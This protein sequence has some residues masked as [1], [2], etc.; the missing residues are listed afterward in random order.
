MP[1]PALQTALDGHGSAAAALD[2]G[3]YYAAFVLAREE[4]EAELEAVALLMC[5]WVEKALGDLERLP[6]QH[7]ATRSYMEFGRWCLSDED[8]ASRKTR[9]LLIAGTHTERG[10]PDAPAGPFEIQSLILARDQK[11]P[12]ALEIIDQSALPDAIILFDVYGP[13]VPEGIFDLGVPVIFWTYDF[14]FHIPSQ[15]EDLARADIILCASV[16]ERYPLQRIYPGRVATFPAH[17]IYTDPA[18]FSGSSGARNIDL[19]HTGISF[20]PMMRG[21]AQFLFEQAIQDDETLDIRLVQGYL[22]IDDYRDLIGRARKIAVVDRLTGGLPTRA[23]DAACAGGAILSPAGVGAHELLRLAGVNIGEA[24]A[25]PDSE[26]AERNLRQIF[27]PSPEREFRFLKFCLFQ[28]AFLKDNIRFTDQQPAP[29]LPIQVRSEHTSACRAAVSL[30]HSFVAKPLDDGIR[31]QLAKLIEAAAEYETSVPL[32]FNLARYLWAIDDKPAAIRLFERLCQTEAEGRFDPALDDIRIH[33]LPVPVELTPYEVYFGALAHDLADGEA[34]APRARR[35]IAASAHCFMGLDHLQEERWQA[36]IK[37]LD[38]ALTL[39][40]DHF[41]AARLRA[42]ALFA[43]DQPPEIVLDAVYAAVRLY[44]PHLTG[45]L[46]IAATCHQTLDDDAGAL[47]LVKSWCYFASRVRWL[48]PEEHP[49]PDETWNAVTPYLD[50]LPGGLAA[51][52]PALQQDGGGVI[53]S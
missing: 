33:L 1:W 53:K 21:K 30:I 17:D 26:A 50:R 34:A 52:I 3:D 20:S 12:T 36:G 19:V 32:N 43:A 22:D 9:L 35:V 16:G 10:I 29:N 23:M 2:A 48:N 5:G 39:C 41:P 25:A 42:R 27:P 4:G 46:P 47:A 44:A 51:K 13:R 6:V 18:R 37:S 28:S 38:Q 31:M 7:A 49:I 24:D 15:Y 14:D 8:L 40:P 45:L 11:A